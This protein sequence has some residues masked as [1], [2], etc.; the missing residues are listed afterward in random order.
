MN[1]LGSVFKTLAG[2]VIIAVIAFGADKLMFGKYRYEGAD[3][4]GYEYPEKVREEVMERCT[5][6]FRKFLNVTD[7]DIHNLCSC[8]L[9]SLE[10]NYSFKEFDKRFRDRLMQYQGLQIEGLL[11]G[12][13][14]ENGLHVN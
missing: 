13:A 8:Y 4:A 11:H 2:L 12:C 5:Q 1:N 3:E 9:D 7:N 10:N 14:R 6:S